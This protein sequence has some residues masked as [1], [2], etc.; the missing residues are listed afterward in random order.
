MIAKTEE[1]PEESMAMQRWGK[2]PMSVFRRTSALEKA[3]RGGD[4]D[5][6]CSLQ[7]GRASNG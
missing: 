5:E 4:C 6:P 3:R 2:T 1:K 7:A